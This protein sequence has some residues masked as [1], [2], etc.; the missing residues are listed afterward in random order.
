MKFFRLKIVLFTFI[1]SILGFYLIFIYQV[2]FIKRDLN[3]ITEGLFVGSLVVILTA[4]LACLFLWFQ[5]R[6]IIIARKKMREGKKLR[7]SEKLYLRKILTRLPVIFIIVNVVGFSIGGIIAN[8]LIT[9]KTGRV[10]D[11]VFLSTISFINLANGVWLALIEKSWAD[12]VLIQ[13]RAELEIFFSEEGI[14]K[15]SNL[16]FA[17]LVA[18]STAFLAAAFSLSAGYGHYKENLEMPFKIA[19]KIKNNQPLNEQ[20][21]LKYDIWKGI[22]SGK[23]NIHIEYD[24]ESRFFE[25]TLFQYW[26]PLLLLFLVLILIALANQFV[27][28][29]QQKKTIESVKNAVSKLAS[30]N[31]SLADRIP[32]VD[33]DEI[34]EL[35]SSFNHYLNLLSSQIQSLNHSTHKIEETMRTVNDFSTD[36]RDTSNQQA[37]SFKQI[38]HAVQESDDLSRSISERTNRVALLTEHSKKD[39]EHGFELIQKNDKMMQHISE[40][41]LIINQAIQDLNDD[42][43]N[44][45]SMVKTIDSISEQTRI[46]AFNAELEANTAGEEAHLFEIVA[47]EIRRLTSSTT[48]FTME[49]KSALGRIDQGA[50]KLNEYT[51]KGRKAVSEGTAIS[52]QLDEVF[53]DVLISSDSSA[54]AVNNIASMIDHSTESIKLVLKTLTE[55]SSGIDN[56]SSSTRQMAGTAETLKD[57]VER[58]NLIISDYSL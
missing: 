21:K 2:L 54:Q 11:P 13:I 12:R 17:M 31:A 14:R 48:G 58:L 43:F 32:I 29:Y 23:R 18:F 47:N 24:Y 10:F 40:I 6:K 28:S 41:M 55:I 38:L 53:K 25:T 36:I 39:I 51:G 20:E 49:I 3:A 22:L 4:A 57:Q 56:F 1:M 27:F 15:K 46:I 34:G 44:I 52:S 5:L 30:G 9:I 16:V 37:V 42:I 35:T 7:I 26:V 19:E 33:F 8:I 50:Q 45:L